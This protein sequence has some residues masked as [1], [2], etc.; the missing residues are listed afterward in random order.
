MRAPRGMSRKLAV[1]LV[2]GTLVSASACTN[3]G[4]SK[5]PK[6]TLDTA[7]TATQ[8]STTVTGPTYVIASVT[9]NAGSGTGASSG[10]QATLFFDQAKSQGSIANSCN[11]ATTTGTDIAKQCSCTFNWVE[12]NSNSGSA[13]PI[14]RS[15]QTSVTTV[16][17]NA[18]SCNAPSVYTNEILDG[19]ILKISV[20]PSGTNT[21]QFNVPKFSFIKRSNT[22][23]GAFQDVNGNFF[24]NI[25]RYSCYEQYQRGMT[26]ASYK[27]TSQTDPA[28][29]QPAT[30]VSASRFCISKA[31][32]GGNTNT[33][34]CLGLPPAEN[35][36][37][38][39]Y[40]NLFIQDSR[41]GDI[42]T[43]NQRYKCPKVK[44]SLRAGPTGNPDYWPLDTSFALS[45]SKTS[46]FTV[47]VDA[48]SLVSI[49]NESSSIPSSCADIA[50]GTSSSS[51][52]IATNTLVK[53]C[54]GWAAKPMTDGTC[55]SYKNS[56]G[57]ILFTYRLRRFVA[58]YPPTFDTDGKMRNEAQGIDTVYVVDRPVQAPASANPLVPYT[59]RGAKPCPFAYFDHAGVLG[60]PLDVDYPG[61]MPGYAATNYPGWN[62][63]NVDGIQ[64]PNTDIGGKS[65]SAAIPLFNPR[66]QKWSI[67]T[68][69][70]TNP[71]P[72]LRHLYIRPTQAWAPH[73]V[74]DTEF[75]A[76][77][78]QSSP[79]IDPP[80]HFSKDPTN[81][82]VA[83][84][85]E[86]YPT[87]NQNVADLDKRS[88][89]GTGPFPG[90][91]VPFTSHVVKNSISANCTYSALD[92]SLLGTA[93][94]AA[95][96]GACSPPG[97]VTGVA[98]HPN[99]FIVDAMAV[100]G[101]SCPNGGTLFNGQCY[102]CSQQTCDRTVTR[103][104]TSS[105]SKYPLL[106]RAAQV[107]AALA[108][109]STYGCT[110][111]YDAGGGKAGKITP[112]QGCC[113]TSV[114]VWTGL[115]GLLSSQEAKNS[116]AHFEPSTNTQCLIPQY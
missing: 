114:K 4:L 104:G 70:A 31:D 100:P 5:L 7:N 36:S 111:T 88:T 41:K 65:C 26:V 30:F 99:N 97:G 51:T 96:A 15:V 2:T 18:I 29:G 24:D 82:N 68:L 35:T 44:E 66:S 20:V 40:Y 8:N 56:A 9:V 25:L 13:G 48:F 19:T 22:A 10:L 49:G 33:Q 91:V 43:E 16:Q 45:V 105:W 14:T 94:P 92:L 54:I 52:T 115:G 6:A 72:A 102:Y 42:N 60:D 87:Q 47:G 98:N 64:F 81:G 74:E 12:Q 77:A 34:G 113:G 83:W 76:C 1:L 69:N 23:T 46:D 103:E 55:P 95:T 38:A 90:K 78:P 27:D 73:Y 37:Q 110:I 84:C 101:A 80:M 71:N 106:A 107:E 11:L 63:V 67:G 79:V 50:N 39:Y 116:F 108:G 112:K 85:A 21:S 57:G 62:G 59:M 109:D 89:S 75:M 17:P 58:L 3:S 32:G 28:T 86:T 61:G 53:K 93:Y